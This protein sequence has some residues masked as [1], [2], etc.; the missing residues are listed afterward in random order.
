MRAL[1]KTS[2][3]AT[4]PQDR[5][6]DLRVAE[7]VLEVDA[8]DGAEPGDVGGDRGRVGREAVLDVRGDVDGQVLEQSYERD[9][10]VGGL[11]RPV[12]KADRRCDPEAGRP[13]G[14][15]A[16]GGE[17]RR[18]R[19]VPRVGQH[20][21]VAGH[22]QVGEGGHRAPSSTPVASAR[23]CASPGH[24]RGPAPN[25]CRRARRGRS[26]RPARAAWSRAPA[27]SRAARPP[28]AARARRG[29]APRSPR[30]PARAARRAAPP[31][32]L[33][34]GEEAEQST[35]ARAAA[36]NSAGSRSASTAS[37]RARRRAWTSP[38]EKRETVA[39]SQAMLPTGPGGPGGGTV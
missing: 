12:G 17:G 7:L 31:P 9:R 15:E 10:G 14:G 20:E 27:A 8:R 4:A 32:R 29:R 16:G 37:T 33:G 18:G 36:R 2:P 34:G 11:G 3:P 28:A 23:A 39:R 1:M 6:V 22:V 19:V 5:R 13:D 30:R 35:L 26:R 38:S 25:G 24:A 21:R